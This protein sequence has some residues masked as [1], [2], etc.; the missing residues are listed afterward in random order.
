MP[1]GGRK[2]HRLGKVAK[3][4]VK[5]L[6]IKRIR[7]RYLRFAFRTTTS[8]IRSSNN[9]RNIRDTVRRKA[10]NVIKHP[11]KTT[12]H[13]VNRFRKYLSSRFSWRKN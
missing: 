10:R 13:A 2:A 4:I 7:R 8:K 3:K 9:Y 12:R 6:K 1:R 11:I 5:Q